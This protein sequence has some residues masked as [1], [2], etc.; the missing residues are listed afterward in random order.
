MLDACIVTYIMRDIF[1]AF[2]GV[3]IKWFYVRIKP[4][5]KR[6]IYFYT[7]HDT[8]FVRCNAH[9]N[10]LTMNIYFSLLCPLQIRYFRIRTTE[11]WPFKY[12]FI[13]YAFN[14][15]TLLISAIFHFH[16]NS[17]VYS[18]INATW[19]YFMFLKK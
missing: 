9:I 8:S 12:A 3:T 19:R 5:L 1:L 2:C 13:Q 7:W 10:E 15:Q 14:Q 4:K 17:L 11:N 16:E 18:V 6:A